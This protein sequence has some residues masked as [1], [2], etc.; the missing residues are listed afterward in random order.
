MV[1]LF[2]HD[3]SSQMAKLDI[4]VDILKF[5][6]LV[7]IMMFLILKYQLFFGKNCHRKE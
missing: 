1:A 4:Y 7:E 6:Y 3:F 5:A 2:V